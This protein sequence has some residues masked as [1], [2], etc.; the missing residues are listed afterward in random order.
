MKHLLLAFFLVFSANLFTAC[1]S[2]SDSNVPQ[3][4]EYSAE[5]KIFMEKK[6]AGFPSIKDPRF[7]L[8]PAPVDNSNLLKQ[9]LP[10]S[11]NKLSVKNAADPAY[12]LRT[13]G[14]VT[15]VKDQGGCGAC[16]SFAA[17]ASLESYL[18]PGETND[19]S[20]NN[21]KDL[22]G[23]D[24]GHCDGG[25]ADMAAAYFMRWNGPVNEADDPYSTT[26]D[27]FSNS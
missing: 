26:S 18:M 13:Y 7:G 22:H 12:D 6:K 14:R 20:E 10:S 15:S 16:W 11:K 17:M 27:V 3:I 21:L 8:I 24:L 5:F 25:N 1:S 23:F 2:N 9:V 4:G 19:F